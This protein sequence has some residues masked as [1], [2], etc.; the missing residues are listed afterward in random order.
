[1]A[2]VETCTEL[3]RENLGTMPEA[4]IMRCAYIRRHLSPG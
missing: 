4:V 3:A 2:T 1:L